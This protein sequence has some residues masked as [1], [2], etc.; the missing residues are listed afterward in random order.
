M[1]VAAEVQ[2]PYS[3]SYQRIERYKSEPFASR[4]GIVVQ[5]YTEQ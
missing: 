2:L 5:N 4:F 3:F 1:T